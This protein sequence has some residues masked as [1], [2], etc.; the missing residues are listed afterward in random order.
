MSMCHTEKNNNSGARIADSVTCRDKSVRSATRAL[1]VT[2]A[3]LIA[4][5][6]APAF[7]TEPE[8]KK[9]GLQISPSDG[10]IALDRAIDWNA[11]RLI[12]VQHDGRY[13]PFDSYAR[14]S[15]TELSGVEQWA[16]LSPMASMLEWIF[17]PEPYL[18]I[19]LVRVKEKGL[20]IHF[21]AHMAP[22]SPARARIRDSG[23]MTPHEFLDPVVEQRMRELAPRAEMN[24]AMGRVGRTRDVLISAGEMTRIVPRPDG[25]SATRWYSPQEL[26][27][28]LAPESA[29]ATAP[30]GQADDSALSRFGQRAEG[31]ST[32][33]AWSVVRAW[34]TLRA[35]WLKRDAAEVQSSLNELASLLPTLAKPD[36]Y[37]SVSQRSAEARY[38]AM[39]KFTRGWMIY[40]AAALISVWALVT[41]WKT[42][43]ALGLVLVT[44]AMAY[45][46]YGVSLRWYILGRVP[47]ASVFEAVVAASWVGVALAVVLEAV[48]RMRVYLLAASLT[49]F[50]ALIFANYVI[51][52][53][54]T[55][56]TIK[57]ILDDVMLRIHT[58]MIV[59]SYALIFLASMIGFVYLFGYYLVKTPQRSAETGMITCLV[60]LALWLV[61]AK[62]FAVVEAPSSASGVI[63][64]Q[65]V[66]TAFGAVAAIATGLFVALGL[67]GKRG[68]A[69]ASLA[70]LAVASISVA[71][72]SHDFAVTMAQVMTYG[73]ATWTTLTA[74]GLMLRRTMS[75]PEPVVAAVGAG[76]A[77][78]LMQRPILAGGA[79]GDEGQA[80]KLPNWLHQFDW[81]HLIILNLVFVLL[82]V[83]I[84]LGAVWADYSWGR[85]WGWDPK[86]VFAMNTW[87]IYAI[88][89]HTRFFA[90]ER[91]L[92]TA[93]LSVVGCLAMIFNWV[94]VNY[95]IVGLH[96]YA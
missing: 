23:Y 13:K 82:F 55:I 61:T 4:P 6:I 21:T 92:A 9:S 17:N 39:G 58:T 96:S 72:G 38:Y 79:P 20:Q 44:V 50:F 90:R 5:V 48:Y 12:A 68:P 19:P 1:L 77:A 7:A 24:T 64:L 89:I 34:S 43:W 86:E 18:D 49:G 40:F 52:G 32:E 8:A 63:K 56:T 78:L 15:L 60:G 93:W 53:G 26:V 14:E 85:P 47:V 62:V 25:D 11:A 51:P 84:I 81:C 22:D 70:C 30:N 2:F 16:Q 74:I 87:I 46:A 3:V 28:N 59:S 69:L 45:H 42:P 41:R 29:P 10:L 27:P 73:G 36:V 75:A 91:G 66:T 31:V 65:Y 95:F 88:L 37:P 83:G 80:A 54:G 57:G 67:V 33:Q 94:V 35:A 76:G 71:V